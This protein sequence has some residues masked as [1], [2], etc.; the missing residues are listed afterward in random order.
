ME[1]ATQQGR[2]TEPGGLQFPACTAPRPLDWVWVPLYFEGLHLASRARS[3][4]L[5]VRR[6]AVLS[7]QPVLS[8]SL[9]PALLF[10]AFPAAQAPFTASPGKIIEALASLAWRL[11]GG[12]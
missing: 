6:R 8:L 7:A 1:Q 4:Q 10:G 2:S 3:P 11:W 12:I 5:L 9:Q